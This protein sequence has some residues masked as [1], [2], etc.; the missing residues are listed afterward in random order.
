MRG[1]GGLR[2]VGESDSA[3]RLEY[4]P[5]L[6]AL[7][8]KRVDG[9]IRGMSASGWL[10]PSAALQAPSEAM[11]VGLQL[12]TD[13]HGLTKANLVAIRESDRFHGRHEIDEGAVR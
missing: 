6:S 3:P 11:T 13:A 4:L 1:E 5:G 7:H 2:I 9:D 10:E 12:E 8:V